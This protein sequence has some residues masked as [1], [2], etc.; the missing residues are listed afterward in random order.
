MRQNCN[1][2]GRE[3]HRTEVYISV[4]KPFP[5]PFPPEMIFSLSW[6]ANIYFSRTRF[7]FRLAPFAF[8]LHFYFSFSLFFSSFFLF[9]FHFPLFCP[10][11]YFSLR[12]HQSKLS[13]PLGDGGRV[14]CIFQHIHRLPY[15]QW[16]IWAVMDRSVEEWGRELSVKVEH[17][18]IKHCAV[19]Q[20]GSA[21]Q[22]DSGNDV[23]AFP[24]KGN[25]W[26]QTNA[27]CASF[28]RNKIS[29]QAHLGVSLK[30]C[31]A[32]V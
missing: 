6:Y 10:P 17:D 4:H 24:R 18:V 9:L 8:I 7:A 20:W 31:K 14:G 2:D 23:M 19:G 13:S 30:E 3:I 26:K 12:W 15:E 25:L 11:T 16:K 32:T 1:V 29:L 21:T 5:R 27:F 22:G 28:L